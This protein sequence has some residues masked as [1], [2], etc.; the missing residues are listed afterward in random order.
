MASVGDQSA[1]TKYRFGTKTADFYVCAACGVV[2]FVVSEINEKTF[3]VVNF[4]SLRNAD[5]L[6]FSRSKTNF[7]GE[8]TGA[9]LDRRERYWIPNVIIDESRSAI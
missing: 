3:A 4:N 9:R 6:S 2:P 7:D 8:D 5:R 1:V